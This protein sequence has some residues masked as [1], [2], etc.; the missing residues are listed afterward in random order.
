MPSRLQPALGIMRKE[1]AAAA[2]HVVPF[3]SRRAPMRRAGEALGAFAYRVLRE[4]IRSGSFHPGEHLREIDVAEWLDISRTPVREAFHRL[5]SERLV[6][7]GPWNGVM[8]AQLTEKQLVQLYAVREALEG[9]AAALAAVHA[10]ASDVQTMSAV[11]ANEA[12]A[13][14][15]PAKLVLINGKF[16]RALYKASYNPY[17]LQSLNSVIDALGL[18]R[19]STFVLPGSI[20][21]ARQEH[22]RILQAVSRHQAEEAEK[23]ARLHVR[24][25]LAMRLE[26]L[27]THPDCQQIPAK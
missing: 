10:K 13:S 16:H 6:T 21:V 12:A 14:N 11:L 3:E 15:E 27:R 9:T 17:L 2:N 7:T 8:I 20:E 19:H 22:E 18:L 25:A 24:N 23:A 5:A 26:L 1:S 4:A